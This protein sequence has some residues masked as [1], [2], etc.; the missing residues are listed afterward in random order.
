[1]CL[2]FL[3]FLKE[4]NIEYEE[5]LVTDTDFGSQLNAHKVTNPESEGTS[6]TYGYYPIIFIKGKAY[7]GFN[8]DIGEEIINLLEKK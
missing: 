8:E 7:S 5:H 2:D 6:E 3:K 4:H 1:M